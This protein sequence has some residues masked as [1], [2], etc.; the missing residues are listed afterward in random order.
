[1]VDLKSRCAKDNVFPLSR[2]KDDAH[3]E[4]IK[5]ED[6]HSECEKEVLLR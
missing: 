6:E 3:A 5:C 2:N 4:S 1:M